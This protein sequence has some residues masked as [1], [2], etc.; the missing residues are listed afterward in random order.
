[1]LPHGPSYA[2]SQVHACVCV[3]FYSACFIVGM[4]VHPTVWQALC[5]TL[6]MRVQHRRAIN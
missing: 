2:C 4:I 1:M 6:R 3:V 5:E